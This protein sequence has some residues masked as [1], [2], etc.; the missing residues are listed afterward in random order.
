MHYK[1]VSASPSSQ[2]KPKKTYLLALLVFYFKLNWAKLNAK[3]IL[4]IDKKKLNSG[5]THVFHVFTK[6]N[7]I[8]FEDRWSTKCKRYL[9]KTSLKFDPLCH[10]FAAFLLK[11]PI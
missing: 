10:T 1:P 5:R 8:K 4:E 6:Y 9:H 11:S 7:F 2:T 3:K